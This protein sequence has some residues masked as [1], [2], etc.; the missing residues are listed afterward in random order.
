MT[1]CGWECRYCYYCVVEQ[2]A[3]CDEV[4]EDHWTCLRCGGGV[5]GVEKEHA[6]FV[7]ATDVTTTISL[8]KTEDHDDNVHE[9]LEEEEEEEDEAEEGEELESDDF[10]SVGSDAENS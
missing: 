4:G 5:T 9:P 7:E 2:L 8:E 6:V 1:D 3:K 10:E